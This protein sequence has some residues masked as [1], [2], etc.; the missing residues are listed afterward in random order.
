MTN[1][2][3]KVATAKAI[4]DKEFK[5]LSSEMAPGIYVVNSLVQIQGTIKK[6]EPFETTVAAAANPWKLLTKALSKLNNTTIAAL[7]R[8][9]LNTSEEEEETVKV[10]VQRAID[11][12]VGATKRTS[13]G[14]ITGQLT[15]GL[16]S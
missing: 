1:T 14:R 7:V 8:E 2:I 10:E 13:S 11:E 4:S 6:G 3:E 5:S 16:R 12:I 15:W 9:S